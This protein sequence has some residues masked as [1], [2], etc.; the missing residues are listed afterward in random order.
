M[1]TFDH[2]PSSFCM[3]STQTTSVPVSSVRPPYFHFSLL[4]FVYCSSLRPIAYLR[5]SRNRFTSASPAQSP[6]S[7]G[8]VRRP[9]TVKPRPIQ[10]PSTSRSKTIVKSIGK[11]ARSCFWV[12]RLVSYLDSLS[13]AEGV[14]S[15]LGVGALCCWMGSCTVPRR[16]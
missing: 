10:T 8:T 11:N 5:E 9:R 1:G 12:R 6:P 13:D 16:P 4:P 14:V 7:W 3:S 2:F 15:G